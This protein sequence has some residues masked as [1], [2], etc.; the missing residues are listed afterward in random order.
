MALIYN[1]TIFNNICF[2]LL[3]NFINSFQ[4]GVRNFLITPSNMSCK[5]IL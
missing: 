5:N 1:R 4:I 2:N 3:L